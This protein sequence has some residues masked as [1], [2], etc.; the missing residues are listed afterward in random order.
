[1]SALVDAGLLTEVIQ[2]GIDFP[3]TND[4]GEMAARRWLDCGPPEDKVGGKQGMADKFLE[5]VTTELKPLIDTTYR[6]R[7]ELEHTFLQGYSFG[8]ILAT[9]AA[10]EFDDVFG[11]VAPQSAALEPTYVK[12]FLARLENEQRRDSR[13]YFDVGTLEPTLFAPVHTVV[14]NMLGKS[15]EYVAQGDLRF[16]VG[17]GHSHTYDRAAERLDTLGG[18]LFPMSGR[19]P[20]LFVGDRFC[21]GMTNQ[22]GESSLIYAE[23]SLLAADDELTL[24]AVRVPAGAFGFFLVGRTAEDLPGYAG[25]LGR[26]CVGGTVV[27]FGPLRASPDGVLRDAPILSGMAAPG[28]T[29]HLQAW[30]RD[31]VTSNT[32]DA[33][34]LTFE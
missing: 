7:S 2:I 29:L 11:G 21:E 27:R 15:P 24:S 5:F 19:E 22:T 20:A 25:G 28:V 18:L 12:N 14:T 26:Q 9:Y 4:F 3:P 34:A 17:Y 1:M 8:G 33:L 6:T 10:W 30:Y 31:G 23:G 13:M 32:S 16:V